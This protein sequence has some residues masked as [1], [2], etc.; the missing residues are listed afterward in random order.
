[1]STY[2]HGRYSIY[3]RPISYL[4]D[5]SIIN[6]LAI[7]YFFKSI[8]P[9]EFITTASASWVLLSLFSKFYEVYRY[10]REITIVALIFRQLALFT[11]LMLAYSG[12]NYELNIAP[13][14]IFKY[15]SIAFLL[16]TFFKF[17]FY[18]LLQKYRTAFGGNYRITA[19]IGKNKQ[20]MAL[21]S[22][23]NK[24]AFKGL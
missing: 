1:V 11:L 24:I 6:G 21:E 3:I 5:L 13:K 16:I 12:F 18:Y 23:F 20:T 2:K 14:T 7:L 10:T 17:T 8:N 22:F 15:V 19:I 9:V 4:I